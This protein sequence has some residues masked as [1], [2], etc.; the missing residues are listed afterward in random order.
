MKLGVENSLLDTLWIGRF[1]LAFNGSVFGV[2]ISTEKKLF[3]C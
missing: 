1:W 2:E 3:T